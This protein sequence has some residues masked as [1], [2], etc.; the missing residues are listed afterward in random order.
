MAE[1]KDRI[2]VA[3]QIDRDMLPL[4]GIKLRRWILSCWL[5]RWACRIGG[6]HMATLEYNEAWKEWY[7]PSCGW[8]P[9]D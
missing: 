5:H 2:N 7:C 6:R 3:K 4:T 9:E 1:L 8:T